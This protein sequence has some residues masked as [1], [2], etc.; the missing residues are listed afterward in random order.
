MAANVADYI[1]NR[2]VC[3]FVFKSLYRGDNRDSFTLRICHARPVAA[4]K[5]AS[6]LHIAFVNERSLADNL[7][8]SICVFWAWSHSS[9]SRQPAR[10]PDRQTN[11]QT[12][13]Q[14]CRQTEKWC[15]LRVLRIKQD[16]E[17]ALYRCSLFSVLHA[18]PVV[19]KAKHPWQTI[20]LIW[21]K[22]VAIRFI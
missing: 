3:I 5:W 4:P 22:C 9:S 7:H 19:A 15:V 12:D 11:R 20:H 21:A 18:A 1:T 6:Y 2:C 8:L 17:S 16:G 10:L 14:T 13:R